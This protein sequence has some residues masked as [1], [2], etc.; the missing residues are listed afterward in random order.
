LLFAVFGDST[1][2]PWNYEYGREEKDERRKRNQ[3]LANGRGEKSRI[4]IVTA[5]KSLN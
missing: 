4:V 3:L 2:Q 5:K 1:V